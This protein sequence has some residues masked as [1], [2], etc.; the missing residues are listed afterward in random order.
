MNIKTLSLLIL[1]LISFAAGALGKLY[2]PGSA[3]PSLI[4]RLISLPFIFVWYRADARERAYPRST[5]L[6][7]AVLIT[8]VFVLPYYFFRSRGAKRG[9]VACLLL[10]LAVLVSLALSAAGILLAESLVRGIAR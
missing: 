3:L 7:I 4:S 10:A 9:S 5:G 2:F 6:D 1:A 8:P